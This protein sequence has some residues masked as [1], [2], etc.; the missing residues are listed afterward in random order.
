MDLGIEHRLMREKE[1]NPEI[2]GL[3]IEY[4]T[5]NEILFSKNSSKFTRNI[6]NRRTC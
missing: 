1:I 5:A 2:M 4:T 6:D 3:L